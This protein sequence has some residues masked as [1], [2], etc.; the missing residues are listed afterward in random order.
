MYNISNGWNGGL[1]SALHRMSQANI[2]LGVL[3][4]TKLYRGIY[5]QESAG[6]RVMVSYDPSQHRG[7]VDIFY[8]ESPHFA[9]ESYQHPG[10]NV[11]SFHLKTGA[12]NWFFVGRY[13]DLDDSCPLIAFLGPWYSA[14]VRQHYWWWG[15]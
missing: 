1:E 9:V 5:A 13:P 2:D 6:Y 12:Q 8:W 11:I 3:Q 15:T 10:L 14:P 4:Q 7:S